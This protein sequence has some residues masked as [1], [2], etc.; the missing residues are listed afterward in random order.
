M[1]TIGLR[2]RCRAGARRSARPRR[3]RAPPC[4]RPHGEHVALHVRIDRGTGM[5]GAG[6]GTDGPWVKSSRRA[7]TP[8]RCATQPT[9]IRCWTESATRG[10]CCSHGTSEFYRRRDE[11]TRR[12]IT[13]KGFSFAQWRVTGRAATTCTAASS[14]RPVRRTIRSRCC[15]A[16]TAGRPGCGPTRRSL[17]SP[18]GCGRTTT[19]CPARGAW[20]SMAW[21]STACGTR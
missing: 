13:E 6:A 15:A 1:P 5:A 16:S 3:Q 8:W 18:A 11:I 7:P 20:G 14:A 17:R 2:S 19:R 12:L 9:S 21:T 10:T 4:A